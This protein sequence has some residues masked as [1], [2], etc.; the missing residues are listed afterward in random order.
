LKSLFALEI[1]KMVYGGRGMGRRDGKVIFV[2]FTAPG[3]LV[4]AE[5]TKDRKEFAEA[6]LRAV[7]RPSPLRIEPFCRHYGECGGCHYQHIPYP[8]QLKV[9]EALVRE[10]LHK[11]G[12]KSGCEFPPIVPSPR[13]RGYRIRAQFK[14][15][16]AGETRALGFYAGSSHRLVPVAQC[17]LLHPKVNEIYR[18]L[19]R[20][21]GEYG[22][23]AVK[24]QVSPD[25]ERGV[26]TLEAKAGGD[27]KKAEKLA[28]GIPGVKGVI[29]KGK[30]DGVF[31]DTDLFWEW[32]GIP[33]S[34]AL[35]VRARGDSFSQV[36]PFQN[37]NL[38]QKIVE[39]ADLAGN[40]R[41]LDLYCGSGNFSLPL[42]QRAKRVWGIDSDEQ[43]ITYARQNAAAN[44]LEN[45]RFRAASTNPGIK[46]VRE[47]TDAVD[48]AVLDPPRAGARDL[49]ALVSL[50]PRKI[51]YVSCEPPIMARDLDLLGS[52]GYRPVR[53]QALDMFPHTYHVEVLAELARSCE[54]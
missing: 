30:R 18:E 51:L 54:D 15:G 9:K 21:C 27:R 33:G 10:C 5:I 50:N 53:L 31:G 48:L 3:E 45:C 36:N 43:A 39:W 19:E 29:L 11:T 35:R 34:R 32:S 7:E 16:G 47:E 38:M 42:A 2:P 6:D 20:R 13:D 8:E 40:E 44:G 37:R 14:G 25:E 12:E 23:E 52:L 49:A 28:R 22:I 4:Q 46:R 24:I 1:E 41:V 26:V 17:P